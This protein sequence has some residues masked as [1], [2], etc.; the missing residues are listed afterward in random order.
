M[1]PIA[2]SVLAALQD[3]QQTTPWS[4]C[5]SSRHECHKFQF[6]SPGAGC[7]SFSMGPSIR[8]WPSPPVCTAMSGHHTGFGVGGSVVGSCSSSLASEGVVCGSAVFSHGRTT[9]P[10]EGFRPARSASRWEVSPRPKT[11]PTIYLKGRLFERSCTFRSGRSQ[12]LH[13]C[14]LPVQLGKFP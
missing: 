10:T 7:S 4:L 5:N 9:R 14:P 3:L 1:V 6:L 11:Y 2:S 12:A 13:D 8:L